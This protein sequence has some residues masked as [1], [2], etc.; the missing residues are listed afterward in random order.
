MVRDEHT[1]ERNG[2]D[3]EADDLAHAF[4]AL[5]KELDRVRL[6]SEATHRQLLQRNRELAAMAAVAQATSSGQLDLAGT[7][8]RAYRRDPAGLLARMQ[9]GK[10]TIP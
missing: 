5:L 7:L 6:E 9:L 1:L 10:E 4:A 2:V 3:A 8:G